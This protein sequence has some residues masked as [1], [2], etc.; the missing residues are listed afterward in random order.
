MRPSVREFAPHITD[1]R[2]TWLSST[3]LTEVIAQCDAVIFASGADHVADLVQP[4]IPCFEYR[5]APDPGT[6]ETVLVPYLAD[7]RR[8]K[9]A[10]N[11]TETLVSARS[12]TKN[13]A[14]K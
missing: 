12:Q 13:A 11:E 10:E 8:D 5:H 14:K 1:V 6:L 7:L 9:I 3:D 4:G 2:V